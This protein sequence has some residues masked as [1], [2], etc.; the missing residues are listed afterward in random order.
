MD[1]NDDEIMVDCVRRISNRWKIEIDFGSLDQSIST[2]LHN[3]MLFE[4]DV[5]SNGKLEQYRKELLLG[6]WDIVENEKF[7]GELKEYVQNAQ[8]RM[9]QNFR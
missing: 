5:R 4:D 1:A 2:V 8:Q 9:K 7:I 3:Q 6:E